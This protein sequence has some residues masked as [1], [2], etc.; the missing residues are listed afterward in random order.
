MIESG[1]NG[2][3]RNKLILILKLYDII[4]YKTQK[5]IEA[6]E[7]IVKSPQISFTGVA[8]LQK[9]NLQKVFISPSNTFLLLS[10]VNFLWIATDHLDNSCSLPK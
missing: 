8:Y 6:K 5:M 2:C 3:Y 1:F 10:F 9:K 4:K 7:H